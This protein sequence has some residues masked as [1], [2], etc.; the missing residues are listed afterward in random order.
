MI[1]F[2]NYLNEIKRTQEVEVDGTKYDV[3]K[4]N[5]SIRSKKDAL[6]NAVKA[7][8]ESDKFVEQI[9]LNYTEGNIK[10]NPDEA[11]DVM[12]KAVKYIVQF[13]PENTSLKTKKYIKDFNNKSVN[14]K[15]IGSKKVPLTKTEIMK[16]YPKIKAYVLK[17]LKSNIAAIETLGKLSANKASLDD[18]KAEEKKEKINREKV[19]IK[20]AEDKRKGKVEGKKAGY[21]YDDDYEDPDDEISLGDAKKDAIKRSKGMKV[22]ESIKIQMMK[23]SY[24]YKGN[25]F[26]ENHL[27]SNFIRGFVNDTYLFGINETKE[28]YEDIYGIETSPIYEEIVENIESFDYIT[29]SSGLLFEGFYQLNEKNTFGG[30]R[31]TT[32]GGVLDFMTNSVRKNRRLN[33]AGRTQG[34]KADDLNKMG[35]GMVT[36]AKR[37]AKMLAGD[38]PTTITAARR[39]GLLKGDTSQSTSDAIKN[40][41]GINADAVA[42]LKG[43]EGAINTGSAKD[44]VGMN[45]LKSDSLLTKAGKETKDILA[46]AGKEAKGLLAG[47]WQKLKDFGKPIFDKISGFVNSGVSWAKG[48][49]TQ[50]MSWFSAHPLAQVAI[51]ALLIAGT[52]VAAIKLINKARKAKGKKK[53]SAE[54]VEKFKA[55]SKSDKTKKELKKLKKAS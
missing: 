33:T 51:P 55:I 35:D 15:F 40:M 47:L 22:S 26:E 29:E 4:S 17:H 11:Y 28:M 43:V 50:G 13:Y 37:S 32:G 45:G 16:K 27:Y 53:M 46:P 7:A 20:K 42:K 41:S 12:S 54:E 6:S 34:F 49:A 48:L 39:A 14:V 18:R 10:S 2:K 23:E 44:L 3:K 1:S 25:N 31:T 5:N 24:D 30:G 52:S 21:G 19:N 38:K 36:G 9:L 8:K